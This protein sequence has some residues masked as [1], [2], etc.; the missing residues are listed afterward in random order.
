MLKVARA[1][2]KQIGLDRWPPFLMDR[3]F[4]F[5][6]LA[7]IAVWVVLWFNVV[8][9]FSMQHQSVITLLLLSV[10]YYPVLE[11]ILFRGIVQGWI[12]KR[13]W[14][15]KQLFFLSVAN[16]LTSLLFVVAHFWY[17]P[18]LWALMVIAPSLVYGYFRDKYNSTYPAIVLHCYYNAGFVVINLL[19]Q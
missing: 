18:V 14:G 13:S 16:W 15:S 10:F 8:P 1:V 9:T 2:L 7:G 11:E 4:S 19:A 17:Q 5:A 12:S 6:L 3:T